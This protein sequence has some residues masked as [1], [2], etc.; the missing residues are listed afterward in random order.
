MSDEAESDLVD[1]IREFMKQ[2]IYTQ[3]EMIPPDIREGLIIMDEMYQGSVKDFKSGILLGILMVET[4][5]HLKE[6]E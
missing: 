3:L 4:L 1:S 5:N 2:D 6:N